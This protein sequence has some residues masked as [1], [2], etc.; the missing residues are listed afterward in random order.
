MRGVRLADRFDH[1]IVRL[2]AWSAAVF[3]ASLLPNAKVAIMILGVLGA[4]TVHALTISAAVNAATIVLRLER[5]PTLARRGLA[6]TAIA[7]ALYCFRRWTIE[8]GASSA[9]A[10]AVDAVFALGIVLYLRRHHLGRH[11]LSALRQRR[12]RRNSEIRR[13]PRLRV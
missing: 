1:G 6:L 11:L 3:A 9:H 12:S 10:A 13:R 5:W 7:L 4:A 2:S 8:A